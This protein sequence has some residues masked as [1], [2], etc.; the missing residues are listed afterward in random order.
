M[1]TKEEQSR[2][3]N[4]LQGDIEAVKGLIEK[5]YYSRQTVE[6][7]LSKVK[8]FVTENYMPLTKMGE[9][10]KDTNRQL[11][12]IEGSTRNNTDE[13]S[14]IGASVDKLL[15]EIK[16]KAD[17]EITDFLKEDSKRYALYEDYKEL[18]NKTARPMQKFQD[19][20]SSYT[21]EHH[22]IKQMIR[23]F[24]TNLASKANKIENIKL[25]NELSTK[26][27]IAAGL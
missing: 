27:S 16:L 12:R 15:E 7:K 4:G 18:Y 3:I 25:E 6:L 14:R 10:Q 26:M 22:Q 19:L 8:D 2:N 24:D 21:T 17:K 23:Q 13:I 9:H 11:H 20:L 5:Y 1:A